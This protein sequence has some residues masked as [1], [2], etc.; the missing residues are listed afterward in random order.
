MRSRPLSLTIVAW[1]FIVVAGGGILRDLV[2]LA[3][4]DASRAGVLAEGAMGLGLIWTVRLLGVVGGVYVLRQRAWARW[5]LLAWMIF[6]VVISA[7][8]SLAEAAAHVAIFSVLTYFLFRSDAV[9]DPQ[10]A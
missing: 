4:T 1:I 10:R 3:G 7:F 8:H 6:H 2:A 9:N 5:L